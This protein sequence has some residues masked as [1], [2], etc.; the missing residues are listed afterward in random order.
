MS[1]FNKIR[2]EVMKMEDDERKVI[3]KNIILW[4]NE[5]QKHLDNGDIMQ[6]CMC[7]ILS[8]NLRKDLKN[9]K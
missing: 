7:R 2:K 1:T 8:N 9:L 3:E 4:E 5:V 6:A